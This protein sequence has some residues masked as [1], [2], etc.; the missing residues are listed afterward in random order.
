MKLTKRMVDQ[1][2][3]GARPVYYF[4]TELPGFFRVMP[5]GAKAWGFEYRAGSGRGAPKRR[6]NIAGFGKLTPD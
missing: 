4:D 2:R 1:V 5:S 3:P 6:V